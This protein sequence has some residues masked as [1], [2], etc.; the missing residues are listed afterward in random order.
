MIL[1]REQYSVYKVNKSIKYERQTGSEIQ[2]WKIPNT[3]GIYHSFFVCRSPE[4]L[5]KRI[6]DEDLEAMKLAEE[7]KLDKIKIDE[8]TT[9]VTEHKGSKWE[10]SWKNFKEQNPFVQSRIIHIDLNF[11]IML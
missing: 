11:L 7:E 2:E 10:S 3:V 9:G 4:Q 1:T 8:E 6:E 5:K